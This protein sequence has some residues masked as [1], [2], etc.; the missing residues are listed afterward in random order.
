MDQ[1][2]ICPSL[3]CHIKDK[4]WENFKDKIVNTVKYCEEVR[5]DETKK[6]P[7]GLEVID[8]DEWSLW[9]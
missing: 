5:N 2:V 4:R 7:V 6:K 8:N 9:K 1:Y 3:L